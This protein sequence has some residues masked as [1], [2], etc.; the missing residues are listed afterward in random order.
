MSDNSKKVSE[1]PIAANVAANDRVI[2]LYNVAATPSVRTMTIGNLANNVAQ[3]VSTFNNTAVSYTW[4]GVQTFSNTVYFTEP[5]TFLSGVITSSGFSGTANNTLYVGSIPAADVVSSSQL[6]ANLAHYINYANLVNYVT[7]SQ[8]QSNLSN[9]STLSHTNTLVTNSYTN[10]ISFANT[11]ANTAYTN[12]VAYADT[13][14]N[15]TYA[16]A[17][18]YADTVANTAYSNAIDFVANQSFVNTSQLS[19]NLAIYVTNTNLTDNLANYALTIDLNNYQV[20]GVRPVT[21]VKTTTYTANSTEEI[22]LADPNTAGD[23]ITIS[24]PNTAAN[25]KIYTI[26]NINAANSVLV[27]SVGSPSIIETHGLGTL[28]T[29]DDLTQ[30]GNTVTWVYYNGVYRVISYG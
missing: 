30:N 6:Q 5:V 15:T 10:A 12:A 4:T 23:Q 18:S 24:L 14:A 20:I 21:I 8:L 1:L 19:D 17:V 11:I 28:N 27:D 25:G 9:Y 22:I 3:Y 2:V 13:L 7:N 16:N 26:K 29:Y